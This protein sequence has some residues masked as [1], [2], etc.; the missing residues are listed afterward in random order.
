MDATY[1]VVLSTRCRCHGRKLSHGHH[2]EE[3][4][5]GNHQSEP[6][7]ASS[8]S[9]GEREDARGEGELP[10]QSQD[11]DISNNREEPESTLEFLLFAKLY[12]MVSILRED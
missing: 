4:A 6:D 12:L 9:V 7:G 3:H 10:C 5:A 8:S 2:D 11:N 1:P